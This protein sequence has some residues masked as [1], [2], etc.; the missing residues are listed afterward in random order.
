M[1]L[2]PLIGNRKEKHHAIRREQV[3]PIV[4]PV[5]VAGLLRA[6]NRLPKWTVPSLIVPGLGMAAQYLAHVGQGA[7]LDPVAGILLGALGMAV[8][9]TWKQLTKAGSALVKQEPVPRFGE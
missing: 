7:E 5:L 6:V 9:E 1:K 4:V 8:R 3:I 2:P